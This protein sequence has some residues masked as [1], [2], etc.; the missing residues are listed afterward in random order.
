[1]NSPDLAR[2]VGMTAWPLIQSELLSLALATAGAGTGTILQQTPSK[3]RIFVAFNIWA[4]TLWQR[5]AIWET[6]ISS[7]F[8]LIVKVCSSSFSGRLFTILLTGLG[9]SHCSQG[10]SSQPPCGW[11]SNGSD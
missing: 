1:M 4:C 2:R 5:R 8:R 11:V 9:H 3:T 7:I 10:C 6:L